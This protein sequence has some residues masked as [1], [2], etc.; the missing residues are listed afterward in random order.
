MPAHGPSALI[1]LSVALLFAAIYLFGGRAAFRP[2]QRGRRRFLS[3]AAGISLGYTFVHEL[4]AQIMEANPGLYV[5]PFW[6]LVVWA[7]SMWGTLRPK[8]ND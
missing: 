2:G 3:F 7:V 5:F 1:T 4:P 8:M 6:V